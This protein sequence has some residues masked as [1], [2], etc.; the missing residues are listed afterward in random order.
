M[1]VLSIHSEAQYFAG[2]ERMLGYFLEGAPAQGIELSVAVVET[3][4]MKTILPEGVS[5]IGLPSNQKFSM[6]AFCRQAARVARWGRRMKFDCVHG[7]GGSGLGADLG[8]WAASN[9]PALGTLHDH[10]QAGF[11]SRAAAADAISGRWGL[12]RSSVRFRSS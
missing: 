2:A 10:P 3:E 11:I 8:M 12:R 6:S 5:L 4:K 9:R 7:V 1:H